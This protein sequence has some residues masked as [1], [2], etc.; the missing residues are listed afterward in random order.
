MDGDQTADIEFHRHAAARAFWANKR[1][2]CDKHVP[3]SLRVNFF[4]A[5]VTPVAC[6]GAGHPKIS[7][8]HLRKFDSEWRRYLEVWLDHLRGLIG[9]CPG[10]K[11]YTVGISMSS[12]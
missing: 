8:P 5:V 9:L 4:E 7:P 2:L 6:F 11:Y 12:R 1:I 10:M 3:L